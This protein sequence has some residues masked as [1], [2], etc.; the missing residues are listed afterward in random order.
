MSDKVYVRM[1]E[2]FTQWRASKPFLVDVEKLR[3]CEP[4]YKGNSYEELIEYLNDEV[5]NN[6]DWSETNGE[7]YG[8]DEAYDLIMEDV[9]LEEYSDTR[10]KYGDE[11]LEV[12]VPN[13]E[14][15][16]TG[17]FESFADNM[18]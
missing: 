10:N 16:K 18:D 13:E 12:G 7:L 9:D 15:R 11:W 1:C 5:W 17:G 14:Y 3:K 6:Y 2:K 8:E 4:P